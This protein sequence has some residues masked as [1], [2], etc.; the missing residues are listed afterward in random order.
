MRV[1]SAGL[2]RGGQFWDHVSRPRIFLLVAMA[3]LPARAGEERETASGAVKSPTPKPTA[4]STISQRPATPELVASA[5]KAPSTRGGSK[6]A[7]DGHA[8]HLLKLRKHRS[9]AL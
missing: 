5:D 9:N 7:S 6:L 8:A 4:S 3:T 2:R 1:G